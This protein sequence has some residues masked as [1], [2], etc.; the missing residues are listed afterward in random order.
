MNGLDSLVECLMIVNWLNSQTG[1]GKKIRESFRLFGNHVMVSGLGGQK[2]ATF[3][4]HSQRTI[5]GCPL[6]YKVVIEKWR[7]LIDFH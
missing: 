7:S 2:S 3:F 4:V 6:K 1:C 5:F